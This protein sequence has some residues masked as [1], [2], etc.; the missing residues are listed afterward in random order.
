MDKKLTKQFECSAGSL[1][2]HWELYGTQNGFNY[3]NWFNKNSISNLKGV[4][5]V[6]QGEA[7]VGSCSAHGPNLYHVH[8][9]LDKSEQGVE[10]EGLRVDSRARKRCGS[11]FTRPSCVRLFVFPC[12]FLRIFLDR[13]GRS[14]GVRGIF[15][16]LHGHAKEWGG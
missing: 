12:P 16:R 3:L 14:R 9:F 6:G 8:L 7:G 5:C 10:I 2:L 1:C 13:R 4:I 15:T 11:G